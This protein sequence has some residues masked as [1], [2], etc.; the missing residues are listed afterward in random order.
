[1]DKQFW[2]GRFFSFQLVDELTVCLGQDNKKKFLS[3]LR[4]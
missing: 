1:M 2:G 3:V 4:S